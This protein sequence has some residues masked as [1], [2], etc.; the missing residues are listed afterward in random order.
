MPYYKVTS[1]LNQS[2]SISPNSIFCVSY[3]ENEWVKAPEG[4]G[5]MVFK[6]IES[7]MAFGALGLADEWLLLWECECLDEIKY[8]SGNGMILIQKKLKLLML[9]R[10]LLLCFQKKL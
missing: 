3:K 2:C 7:V 10:I 8:R 6:D 5:L 1:S 4:T 9:E